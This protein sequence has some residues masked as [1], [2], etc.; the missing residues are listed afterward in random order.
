MPAPA[1]TQPCCWGP[2]CPLR[3]KKGIVEFQAMGKTIAKLSSF[4]V[5]PGQRREPWHSWCP[6][7]TPGVWCFM[8]VAFPL[9]FVMLCRAFPM[10]SFSPCLITGTLSIYDT[11]F[12]DESQSPILQGGFGVRC[13][14]WGPTGR[15]MH[16]CCRAQHPSGCLQPHP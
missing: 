12:T 4:E 7:L 6:L 11:G 3:N 10:H 5:F 8:S 9:A 16:P 15:A 2:L 13:S 1:E 14:H